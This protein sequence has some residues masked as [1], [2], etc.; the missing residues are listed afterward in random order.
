MSSVNAKSTLTLFFFF[1]HAGQHTVCLKKPFAKR[2]AF[3][4][5][6]GEWLFDRYKYNNNKTPGSVS[7]HH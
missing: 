4:K 2:S 1:P 7:V 3:G 5:A 6:A